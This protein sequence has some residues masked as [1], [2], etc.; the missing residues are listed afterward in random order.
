MKKMVAIIVVWALILGGGAFAYKM[1]FPEG[2][3]TPSGKDQASTDRPGKD[4]PST[5][6]P[7]TDRPSTDGGT[8]KGPKK[9]IRLALDSFPGYC[10]F[11]SDELKKKLKAQDIELVLEDDQA[12]YPKRMETV[13]KG[14]TP[15]AVF[16]IDALI[17]ASPREGAPPA[18]IV[19][20][21]DETRGADAMLGYKLGLPDLDALNKKTA[22][23]TLVPDS[24]SEMLTRL[25]RSE[26]NLSELPARRADYLDEAKSAE[27]AY[28]AFLKAR[29]NEPH[30]FV[31]W[32][33]YVTLALKNKPE[34]H[35]LV[36]SS[37]FK[38][39][40]VDCLVVQSKYLGEHEDEVR[41]VVQAYLEVLHD[42]QKDPRGM[43]KLVKAD[44]DHPMVN[45]PKIKE[46]A[47]A[48]VKGIWW[49][50]TLENYAH[51]GLLTAEETQGLQHVLD[52]VKNITEVLK[53]T[54][55]P[56][57]PDPGVARQDRLIDSRILRKLFETSPRPF[58]KS[59]E[60]IRQD[61][62]ASLPAA[63]WGKLR[64]VGLLKVAPIK[65][66]RSGEMDE[67]EATLA[68]LAEKLRRWPQYYLRIEGNSLKE[69]DP[70]ANKAK[71]RKRAETVQTYLVDRL[72]IP[73]AR[74][75][76][77]ANEPGGGREVGFVF[78][79]PGTGRG[80]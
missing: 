27:K 47:A 33:P 57:D 2:G 74:L 54:K 6:K 52:M 66:T 34:A 45:E 60:T 70:D 22:R 80:G 78:L 40:I 58:H 65:F 4:R 38:G 10:I 41:A 1:L 48:V 77:T 28:E 8:D 19:M 15:L 25:L 35:V 23:I 67:A 16:T 56:N 7:S 31:L 9:K 64:R 14:D 44:A 24:P 26:F 13:S 79:E 49:K 59:D 37:R 50:N 43:E 18:T 61:A 68:D 32:E 51:F 72:G 3:S 36:D 21:I 12:D 69:G 71:A 75:K 53:Q 73:A 17:N 5:D 20:L 42:A 39:M 76:A 11:R 30:A 29:P 55:Q 63:D 62:T 46:N